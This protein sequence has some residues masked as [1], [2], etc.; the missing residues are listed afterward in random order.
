MDGGDGRNGHGRPPA[1]PSWHRHRWLAP[2]VARRP[3]RWL[4]RW[5]DHGRRWAGGRSRSLAPIVGG[6]SLASI[7]WHRWPN[8]W[9]GHGRRLAGGRWP[10]VGPVVIGPV[11]VGPVVVGLIVG[12]PLFASADILV[13]IP[14]FC[15]I[16][17]E[18]AIIVSHPSFKSTWRK[19]VWMSPTRATDAKKHRAY[20]G[21]STTA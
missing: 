12:P 6:R 1:G 18:S 10:I 14:A 5:L 19:H 2:A 8:L 15:I 20:D 3:H 9:L 21:N 4:D 17:I 16:L 11:V 13:F 7:F